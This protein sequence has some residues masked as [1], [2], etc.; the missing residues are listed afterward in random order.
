MIDNEIINVYCYALR[1][2]C[3]I[4]SKKLF[5]TYHESL[6]CWQISCWQEHCLSD[7]GSWIILAILSG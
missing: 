5:G 3:E 4:K 6:W 2:G 7:G 1:N